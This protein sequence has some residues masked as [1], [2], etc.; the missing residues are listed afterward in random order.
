MGKSTVT[1]DDHEIAAVSRALS[2]P[3]RIKI[4][5]LLA[6]QTEC[7]GTEVFSELPLA[8]STISEHLRVLKEAGLVTS[9]PVGTAMTYCLRREP[10]ENLLGLLEEIVTTLPQ[11]DVT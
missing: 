6:A 11:C 8:Q 10:L 9:S 5:R 1:I 7:R 2:N 3:A 4:L